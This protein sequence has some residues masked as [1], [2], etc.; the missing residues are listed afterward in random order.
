MREAAEI[1]RLVKNKR[2]NTKN[3]V[4]KR[5]MSHF[6]SFKLSLKVTWEKNNW[7]N[8]ATLQNMLTT[9]SNQNEEKNKGVTFIILA[10]I[11]LEL[12]TCV[13]SSRQ[14]QLFWSV[15]QCSLALEVCTGHTQAYVVL[16][17]WNFHPFGPRRRAGD[18]RTLSNPET[19]P[20]PWALWRGPS[21][22]SQ[23]GPRGRSSHNSASP[24]CGT[25]TKGHSS[26][27]TQ[28]TL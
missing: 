19:G 16:I 7:K 26:W 6:N 11:P 17:A 20:Y 25:P 28:A 5:Q 10:C 14:R 1:Q 2:I 21:S 9:K 23:N 13:F 3:K 18:P 8:Y 4:N 12:Q 24:L 15:H 27:Q 22:G